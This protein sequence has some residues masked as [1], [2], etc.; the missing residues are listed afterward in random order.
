MTDLRP[1]IAIPFAT[2]GIDAVVTLPGE[3]P[4]D[5]SIIWLSPVAVE[6]QGAFTRTN[7]PQRCLALQRADVPTVPRGTL[8]AAAEI[9]GGTVSTWCV[10]AILGQT[11]EE[12]RVIVIPVEE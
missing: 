9:S 8:I 6:T 5:T 3:A 10:E 12:V 4:V 11:A 7:E 2:F 1:S